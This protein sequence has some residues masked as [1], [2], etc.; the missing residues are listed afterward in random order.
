MRVKAFDPFSDEK[1]ATLDVQ[2]VDLDT[3]RR[4]RFRAYSC[5]FNFQ[6]ARDDR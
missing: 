1:L 4:V 6:N 3:F 5:A 2:I